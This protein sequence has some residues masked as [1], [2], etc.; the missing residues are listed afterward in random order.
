MPIENKY[1]VVAAVALFL[2]ALVA[3]DGSLSAAFAAFAAATGVGWA[4]RRFSGRR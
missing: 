4:I 2:L 1:V 3:T